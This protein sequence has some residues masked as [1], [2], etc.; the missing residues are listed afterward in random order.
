VA[1]I[2]N[3]R[4]TCPPRPVAPFQARVQ[5]I[6]YR[7]LLH[8]HGA[9]KPSTV[10]TP[11]RWQPANPD[12]SEKIPRKTLRHSSQKLGSAPHIWGQ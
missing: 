12:D 1:G 9:K 2:Y 10:F 3:L 11:A 8:I 5:C 6:V 7:S 4:T